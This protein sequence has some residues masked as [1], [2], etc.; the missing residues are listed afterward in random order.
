MEKE[1]LKLNISEFDKFADEYYQSHLDSMKLTGE[2]PEYF[3]KYKIEA[4]QRYLEKEHQSNPHLVLS[5]LKILDFGS[6]VGNSTPHFLR[7]FPDCELS[8]VD[9]SQKSLDVALKRFP[10]H[11]RNYLFDGKKLPFSDGSFDVVF[12]SCVFHHIPPSAHQSLYLEINRVLKNNNSYFFNFEHNPFNPLT[13]HVVNSCAFDKDAILISP[14]KLRNDLKQA[15]FKQVKTFFRVFFP[16]II[17]RFR[18]LEKHLE[19]LPLGGQYFTV[20]KK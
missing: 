2:D 9:V 14:G 20:G 5:N 6:G 3:A 16:N 18:F 19:W 13:R 17:S 12:T 7:Q 11:H 8:S 1:N 4:I 15:G 10:N